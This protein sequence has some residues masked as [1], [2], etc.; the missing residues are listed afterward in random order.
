MNR[1]G[2][3]FDLHRLVPGRPFLLGGI[4][5]EADVGPEGHSDGDVLLHAITDA[6]LGAAGLGDI[7]D[8]FP[9]GDAAYK[10]ANSADLL[11]TVVARLSAD[12]WRIENVDATVLLEAPKLYPY[13]AQIRE[14][15]A[16]LLGLTVDRV[17]LKAKTME[18]LGPIG[19]GEAVAAMTSA[20]LK[21]PT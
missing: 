6:L 14:R 1:I 7:G 4:E 21:S 5:L 2:Q 20:L 9:P 16:A 19:Q 10:G 15:V 13:K 12:G 3:G 8:W 11:A 17:S 18:R